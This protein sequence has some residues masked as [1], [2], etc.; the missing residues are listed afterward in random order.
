MTS[1]QEW[2]WR[3]EDSLARSRERRAATVRHPRWPLVLGILMAVV[4]AVASIL[5]AAP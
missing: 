3:C 1:T 5:L 4:G 2:R